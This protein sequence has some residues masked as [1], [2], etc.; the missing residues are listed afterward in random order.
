MSYS[1]FPMTDST[2]SK[3]Y[4]ESNKYRLIIIGQCRVYNL[5]ILNENSNEYMSYRQ[6]SIF[7]SKNYIVQFCWWIFGNKVK[8]IFIW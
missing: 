1:K 5:W 2:F 4:G 7:L 3:E 6:S 8:N